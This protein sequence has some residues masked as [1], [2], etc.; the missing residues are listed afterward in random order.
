M[1]LFGFGKK[2]P[3]KSGFFEKLKTGL[4]AT[5]NLLSKRIQNLFFGGAK[6][7]EEMLEKLEEI[8]ITS[9]VGVNTAI[10]I[11]NHLRKQLQ[12]GVVQTPEQ[13]QEA[14]KQKLLDI[15]CPLAKPLTVGNG[16]GLGIMMLVGVNG[17]RENHLQR[18]K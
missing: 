15:L 17:T 9:D 7:D 10:S 11:I 16:S 1:G 12:N 3:E 2:E 4:T 6:L 13:L 18:E 5:R 8:L 14:L